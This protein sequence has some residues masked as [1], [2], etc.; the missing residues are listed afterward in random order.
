MMLRCVTVDS[1]YATYDWKYLHVGLVILVIA[2]DKKRNI[3]YGMAYNL[4]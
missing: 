3:A 2:K 1:A 4:S